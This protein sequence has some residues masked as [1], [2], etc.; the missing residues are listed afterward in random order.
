MA[1]RPSHLAQ[2]D[3]RANRRRGRAQG[4]ACICAR[5]RC[6]RLY[7]E[8]RCNFRAPVE[9]AHDNWQVQ[10]EL[11]D[12]RLLAEAALEARQP[13]MAAPVVE[14]ARITGVHDVRLDKWLVRIEGAR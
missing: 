12:A 1:P 7:V 10:K 3:A 4:S 9:I 2:D 5:K 11:A 6:S 8:R 13:A 14:W